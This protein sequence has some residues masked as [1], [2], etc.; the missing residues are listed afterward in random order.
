MTAVIQEGLDWSLVPAL[1]LACPCDLDLSEP[2][3][4]L[5]EGNGRDGTFSNI[6]TESLRQKEGD[7]W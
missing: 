6:L 1:P 4:P 7:A 2:K 3:I 5:S